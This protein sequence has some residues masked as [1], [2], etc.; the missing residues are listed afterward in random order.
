MFFKDIYLHRGEQIDTFLK[1][2]FNE[3]TPSKFRSVYN[4]KVVC[5]NVAKVSNILII[6]VNILLKL[7][8]NCKNDYSFVS[9]NRRHVHI[10]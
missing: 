4:P 10:C 2:N 7:D 3:H 9:E 8:C 1:I 5:C 6:S